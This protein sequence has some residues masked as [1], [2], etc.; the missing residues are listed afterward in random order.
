MDLATAQSLVTGT[1]DSLR[2]FTRDIE[3]VK[4]AA[5]TF[6]E[7]ANGMLEKRQ[8]SYAEAQ[9]ALPEKRIKRMKRKPG[10]LA[11][12]EPIADADMDYK[13]HVH[14]VILD[15]AVETIHR[16]YAANAVLC[17][18]VSCMDPKCFLEIREKGLPDTAMRELSRCL[19]EIDGRASD[20]PCTAVG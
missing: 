18:D 20:Q 12:D 1:E 9:T 2:K 4:R 14:N 8:D 16:R 5:D 7:W 15:T 11:E 10:E 3:G 19:L 17:T 13:I 6:V